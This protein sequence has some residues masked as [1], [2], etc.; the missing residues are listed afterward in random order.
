LY[1]YSLHT[2]NIRQQIFYI[3]RL[4]LPYIAFNAIYNKIFAIY[5]YLM[6]INDKY[7]INFD[8]SEYLCQVDTSEGA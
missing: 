5:T 8:I 4:F 3:G 7:A 1:S 6:D 2:P